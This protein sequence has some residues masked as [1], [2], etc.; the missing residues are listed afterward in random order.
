VGDAY[1]D[2]ERWTR[3]SILNCARS[4]LFS[5][6]RTIREYCDEIWHVTPRP[7]RLLTRDEV[8]TGIL[9]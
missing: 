1:E 4:G 9:Q 7:V 6:D 3:M 8:R 2:T 5:S